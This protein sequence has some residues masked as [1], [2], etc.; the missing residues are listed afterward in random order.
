MI[1]VSIIG[2][3]AIFAIPGLEGLRERA[4]LAVAKADVRSLQRT[5]LAN[6]QN[7]GELPT[8]EDLEKSVS[9]A[10]D[11]ALSDLYEI[12]PLSD[13]N[14]GHGNDIDRCDEDNPGNSHCEGTDGLFIV[15]SKHDLAL[16]SYVY[17]IDSLG[18][19]VVPPGSDPLGLLN[20]NNGGGNGGGNG[21]NG[22][23]GN[24]GHG[25]GS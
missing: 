21:N 3:L 25:G 14:N 6:L 17:A 22:N 23:N 16:A 11:R 13:D 10:G 9:K 19:V 12:V 24:N 5:V 8:I 18:M 4:Y 2:I 20:G 15:Y 1:T 7:G